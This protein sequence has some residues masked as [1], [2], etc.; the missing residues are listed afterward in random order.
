MDVQPAPP[1]EACY[2][3]RVYRRELQFVRD[4]PDL[5][6]AARNRIG[7]MTGL[8]FLAATISHASGDR[9][10]YLTV[11]RESR[12]RVVWV[13]AWRTDDGPATQIVLDRAKFKP[14]EYWRMW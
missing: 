8:R 10:V 14:V 1:H 3:F 11:E 2:T 5:A 7:D 12:D 6:L 4:Y 9:F 13:K